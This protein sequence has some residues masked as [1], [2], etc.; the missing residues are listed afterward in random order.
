MSTTTLDRTRTMAE[1]L[2]AITDAGKRWELTRRAMSV[3]L[4][5]V[6]EV[7]KIYSPG[8]RRQ[9][10]EL[11]TVDSDYEYLIRM[12]EVREI[13]VDEWQGRS[14]S[15]CTE[16][17]NRFLATFGLDEV[18]CEER[19]GGECDDSDC[20]TCHPDSTKLV[21]VSVTVTLRINNRHD[22]ERTEDDVRNY[23]RLDVRGNVDD[24]EA[25]DVEIDEIYV[26]TDY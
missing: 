9:L 18:T 21:T 8:W 24:V 20:E 19:D 13:A 2:A 12:G 25:S 17:T 11:P 16:G 15:N 5:T 7:D 1:R 6:G 22:E 14:G 3:Y 4:A 26:T 23:L 10:A